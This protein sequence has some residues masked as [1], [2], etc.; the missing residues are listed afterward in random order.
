M[1]KEQHNLTST[2]ILLTFN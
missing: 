2:I 1:Q